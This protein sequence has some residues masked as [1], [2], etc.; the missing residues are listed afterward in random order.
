MLWLHRGKGC[1]FEKSHS[2]MEALP[3][4]CWK[5]HLPGKQFCS[6]PTGHSEY[7]LRKNL[8][9][10]SQQESRLVC[11]SLA[12]QQDQRGKNT[13]GCSDLCSMKC[14]LSFSAH[15]PADTTIT[16]CKDACKVWAELQ[17]PESA[18]GWFICP[19]SGGE[20]CPP[21][22]FGILIFLQKHAQ[23]SVR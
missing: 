2:S 15:L 16:S 6:P 13:V 8:I 3:T 18:G 20:L 1:F 5:K 11:S 17:Q 14:R 19:V 21:L 4:A 12:T 22:L 9:Y 23:I 7:L 10:Y